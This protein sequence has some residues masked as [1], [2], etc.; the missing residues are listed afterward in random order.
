MQD[1]WIVAGVPGSGKTWIA[2]Q[3]AKDFTWLPQED[4]ISKEKGESPIASQRDAIIEAA[5]TSDKPILSESP[6]MIS[7]LIKELR[8]KGL[9]VHPVFVIEPEWLIK[10]RYEAREKKPI[11]KQHLTRVATVKN[12][13][14]EYGVFHGSSDQVL[15]FFQDRLQ[16]D[17]PASGLLITEVAGLLK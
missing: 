10:R 11:P 9:T 16:K 17:K 15:K 3:L 5:K 8:A 1:V 12:R 7:I 4:Y 2:K 13:A 6:F 14:R